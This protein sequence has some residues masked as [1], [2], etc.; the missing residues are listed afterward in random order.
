MKKSALT[1][2]E[3]LRTWQEIGQHAAAR[4]LSPVARRNRLVRWAG[5]GATIFGAALLL[6]LGIW[7]MS[8][9]P[10]PPLRAHASPPPGSLRKFDF[11]TDGVLTE[12]WVRDFLQLHPGDSLEKLDLFALRECLLSSLQV[13]AATVERVLP[14]TLRVS[15]QERKPW[16]RVAADDGLGSYKVYL[17][18]RDGTVFLGE[19]FP[20]AILDQLPWMAGQALHRAKG[21]AFQ[22]VPGMEAVADLLAAARARAPQLAAQWTVVDL[23]QFDPRPQA[24]WSLIKVQAGNLGELTFQAQI[25]DTESFAAQINRLVFAAQQLDEKPLPVLLHGLDLSVKNQVVVQPI[26]LPAAQARRT[27]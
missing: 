18:A 25:S 3:G 1:A 10:L 27:R 13:R 8:R 26:S 21:D 5:W 15:V 24:P 23:S 6:L 22:P 17:V 20:D 19:D 4:D 2:A 7:A 11:S 12:S 16:L 14:G 9:P